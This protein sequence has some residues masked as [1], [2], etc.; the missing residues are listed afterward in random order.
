MVGRGYR[1]GI[2]VRALEQPL[3]LLVHVTAP[4]H[5]FLLLPGGHITAEAL[6]LDAV[7]VAARRHLHTGAACE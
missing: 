4:G 6:A 2:D 1:D 5:A 7:H 3:V